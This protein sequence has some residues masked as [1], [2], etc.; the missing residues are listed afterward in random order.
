MCTDSKEMQSLQGNLSSLLRNFLTELS[1]ANVY[2][3]LEW[4][5]VQAI[6]H[7]IVTD[8]LL[9]SVTVKTVGGGDIAASLLVSV[10]CKNLASSIDARVFV[11]VDNGKLFRVTVKC[12]SDFGVVR[13]TLK[14]D[15]VD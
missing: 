9:K 2:L 3:T 6:L 7:L 8:M 12:T 14:V 10:V 4:D 13:Y 1:S 11:K 15:E 5:E